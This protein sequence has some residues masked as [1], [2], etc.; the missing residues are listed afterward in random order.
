MLIYTV[1]SGINTRNGAEGYSKKSSYFEKLWY[2]LALASLLHISAPTQAQTN[3]PTNT[4]STE[5]VDGSV[6]KYNWI[7][8]PTVYKS[9][10][11]KFI[12]DNNVFKVKWALMFTADFVLWE[13]ENDRWIGKENQLLFV[14]HS[15]Y[16][17]VTGEDLYNWEDWDAKTAENFGNKVVGARMRACWQKYKNWI[18]K[19]MNEVS[20][21]AQQRSADAQQRSADAQQRSAD[22]QQRSADA[23]QRSADADK[24]IAETTQEAEQALNKGFDMVVDFYKSCKTSTDFENF[25][26]FKA[27]VEKLISL[28]KRFD[29]DYRAIILKKLWGDENK[30]QDFFEKLG[31]KEGDMIASNKWTYD[32]IN[33]YNPV[34]TS[35]E[36]AEQW[37]EQR[38]INEV[39]E[40]FK[41]R[42]AL[43]LANEIAD[44][45]S[46]LS[47]DNVA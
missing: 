14:W 18:V 42:I 12:S 2:A 46:K 45:L 23:Q 35:P 38:E 24:Q 11:E 25:K 36:V 30:L 1:M 40:R 16:K 17:Q 3:V 27:D 33:H 39:R 10:L 32:I 43:I 47:N 9:K 13:M 26:S 5:Q 21:D 20:A 19:Y 28:S 37:Y 31:I 4:N 41:N 8:I 7:Y 29:F 22:A 15:I 34:N 6:D 44:N